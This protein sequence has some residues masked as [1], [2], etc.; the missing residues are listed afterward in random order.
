MS[1]SKTSYIISKQGQNVAEQQKDNT[2][3]YKLVFDFDSVYWF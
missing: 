1:P 2:L 3:K